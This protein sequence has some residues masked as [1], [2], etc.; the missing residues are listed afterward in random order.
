MDLHCRGATQSTGT[1]RRTRTRQDLIFY[2]FYVT[3]SEKCKCLAV[4]LAAG[5]LPQHSD[6][7]NTLCCGC[8]KTR[9]QRSFPCWPRQWISPGLRFCR[10][11][12]QPHARGG[13][14]PRGRTIPVPLSSGLSLALPSL[15]PTSG[16]RRRKLVH[17]R[18]IPTQTGC[19]APQRD[20]GQ[21]LLVPPDS[22]TMR[23]ETE[24]RCCCWR[25]ETL[26]GLKRKKKSG[27]VITYLQDFLCSFS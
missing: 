1:V 13:G 26:T 24:N 20:C 12:P 15:A 22:P 10:R 9:L 8:R 16:T 2:Y 23:R 3:H 18:H 4:V 25:P 5:W 21:D 17:S 27:I 11:P 6:H 19:A 7:P 14:S